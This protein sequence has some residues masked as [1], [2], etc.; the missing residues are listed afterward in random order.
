VIYVAACSLLLAAVAV[1][2]TGGLTRSLIRQQAR[3]R[4]A[5]LAKI[6][7]LAGKTWELPPSETWTAPVVEEEERYFTGVADVEGTF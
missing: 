2:A 4:E 7:H 6:M 3:E 1:A 5:L